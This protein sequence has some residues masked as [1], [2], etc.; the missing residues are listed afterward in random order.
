MGEWMSPCIQGP[1]YKARFVVKIQQG[2]VEFTEYISLADC[3]E[4]GM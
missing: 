2:Q 1:K 3:N 4:V